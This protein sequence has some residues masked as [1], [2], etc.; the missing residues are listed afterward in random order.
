MRQ[1][2]L[3]GLTEDKPGRSKN[4]KRDIDDFPEG[5]EDVVSDEEEDKEEL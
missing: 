1:K 2:L 4:R 5:S 3:G